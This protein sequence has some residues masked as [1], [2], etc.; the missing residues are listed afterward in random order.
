[1]QEPSSAAKKG[2]EEVP[3]SND[4]FRVLPADVR[5]KVASFLPARQIEDFRLVDKFWGQTAW[6]PTD[7]D[8]WRLLLARDYPQVFDAAQQDATH[9]LF[10]MLLLER[11][12]IANRTLRRQQAECPRNVYKTL[13]TGRHAHVAK[14]TPG[15]ALLGIVCAPFVFVYY[16]PS[17]AG[18]AAGATFDSLAGAA[19]RCVRALC[20]SASSCERCFEHT[21]CPAAQALARLLFD[22]LV[23]Y[24]FRPVFVVLP[25][26]AYRRVLAPAGVSLREYVVIPVF[27]TLPRLAFDRVLVPSAV[28]ARNSANSL[29]SLVRRFV[30]RPLFVE[31]PRLV[32]QR[33]VVPLWRGVAVPTARFVFR[34]VP[35]AIVRC[36]VRPLWDGVALP[37]WRFATA[38]APVW[39]WNEVCVPARDGVV[40]PLWRNVARP[41]LV[42]TFDTAP[43]WL[44]VQACRLVSDV[45]YP[46]LIKPTFQ[47]FRWILTEVPRFLISRIAVPLIVN[48]FRRVVFPLIEFGFVTLPR[49]LHDYVLLP[50]WRGF[51]I[52]F[53]IARRYLLN[54]FLFVV[55]ALCRVTRFVL[56]SLWT[57]AAAPALSAAASGGK[58]ALGAGV[59]TCCAL[60]GAARDYI[61]RPLVSAAA[62]TAHYA[63]MA[64]RALAGGTQAYVFA[65]LARLVCSVVAAG[66][67]AARSV[68]LALSLFVVGPLV[69]GAVFAARA[70][71]RAA[72]GVRAFAA[73]RVVSPMAVLLHD[74]RAALARAYLA[75]AAAVRNAIAQCRD[76]WSAVSSAAFSG[77]RRP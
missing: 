54:P 8:L 30:L 46:G 50:T 4:P 5:L 48:L 31:L 43:S 12:R 24:A 27:S 37:C 70:G 59:Y 18:R 7:E 41:V 55:V 19:A 26:A 71:L 75:T 10:D 29:A 33:A 16:L 77:T 76:A 72:R 39:L 56:V 38:D 28:F 9:E 74:A 13:E 1:M 66:L 61:A 25:T 21:V 65:P 44:V 67:G 42:F 15:T 23:N 11:V 60:G 32:H 69:R 45:L 73:T 34:E 2:A 58:C 68:R 3:E 22:G 35:A 49:A 53:D 14:L 6:T 40:L 52:G 47:A 36:V 62:E 64:V 20:S 57:G 63:F 51:C 17:M